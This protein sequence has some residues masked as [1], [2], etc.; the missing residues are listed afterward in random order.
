MPIWAYRDKA[1]IIPMYKKKAIEKFKQEK[2]AK[3]ENLDFEIWLLE[4]TE[5]QR[6][7]IAPQAKQ[8]M[9]EMQKGIL[10]NYWKS[11][12]SKAGIA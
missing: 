12:V 2:L 9:S 3:K 11:S 1:K 8:D 6:R 5:E 7:E 10:R 4:T